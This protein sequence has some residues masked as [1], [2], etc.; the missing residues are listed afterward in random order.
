MCCRRLPVPEATKTSRLPGLQSHPSLNWQE[1]P[2][3]SQCLHSRS[4]TAQPISVGNLRA[5][6]R[7]RTHTTG[8]TFTSRT[9]PKSQLLENRKFFANDLFS[10]SILSQIALARSLSLFFLFVL[11]AQF[12]NNFSS[13]HVHVSVSGCRP[14]TS[15]PCF[16]PYASSHVFSVW[17]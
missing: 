12:I 5:G 7:P 13:F 17:W 3:S 4:H 9:R 14:H 2:H 15:Y 8:H 10:S 6:C 11:Y 16:D 1:S